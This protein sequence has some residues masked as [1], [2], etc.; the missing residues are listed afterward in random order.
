MD[1]ESLTYTSVATAVRSLIALA[2]NFGYVGVLSFSV[3]QHTVE[4]G[5][6]SR[7]LLGAPVQAADCWGCSVFTDSAAALELPAE[8][9]SPH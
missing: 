6:I 1:E 7:E 8:I 5:C 9:R 3:Q 2:P 4:G